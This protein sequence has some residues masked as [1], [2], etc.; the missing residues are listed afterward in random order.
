MNRTGE[1]QYTEKE[2]THTGGK[3]YTEKEMTHTE[4]KQITDNLRKTFITDSQK[5]A[6]EEHLDV[7][8]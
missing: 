3:Q 8:Q 1:Q 4:D 7:L 2:M 5:K 6:E